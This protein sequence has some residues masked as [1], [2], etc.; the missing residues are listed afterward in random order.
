LLIKV[1]EFSTW[2]M[3]PIDMLNS[4]KQHSVPELRYY[5]HGRIKLP[6]VLKK[7][8]ISLQHMGGFC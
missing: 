4:K 3:L 1:S 5:Q 6:L 7:K 2:Q 8:L